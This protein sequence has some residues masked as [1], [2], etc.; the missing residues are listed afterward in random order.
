VHTGS[1]DVG[2]KRVD[3]FWSDDESVVASE[4]DCVAAML[5]ACCATGSE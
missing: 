4:S 1:D 5:T 2:N 3:E